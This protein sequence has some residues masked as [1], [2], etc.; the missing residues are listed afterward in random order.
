M[1]ASML[2]PGS[3]VTMRPNSALSSPAGR[4]AV[5]R[6]ARKLLPSPRR[7]LK[8]A[9]A[10]SPAALASPECSV[11]MAAALWCR[12]S[13]SGKPRSRGCR[14]AFDVPLLPYTPMLKASSTDFRTSSLKLPVS[15]RGAITCRSTRFRERRAE[16]L[17]AMLPSENSS[18]ATRQ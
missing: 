14:P 6:S 1:A 17:P 3:E 12:C 7:A 15:F 8:S 2:A 11:Q 10:A 9:V 4:R 13:T 16:V 5:S 18:W